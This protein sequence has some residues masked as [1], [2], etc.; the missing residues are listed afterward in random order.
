MYIDV[1]YR[2]VL[3]TVVVGLVLFDGDVDVGVL[4]VFL[5][6]G[7]VVQFDVFI[8]VVILMWLIGVGVLFVVDVED[9]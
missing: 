6:D 3:C 1:V 8:D 5:K 4:W 2:C 9:G 7:W